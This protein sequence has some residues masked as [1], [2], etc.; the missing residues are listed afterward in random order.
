MAKAC[1]TPL[2]A[3]PFQTYRDPVTGQW[4]IVQTLSGDR[5]K[6]HSNRSNMKG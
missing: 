5:H 6:T 3:N 2:K 4:V 1:E